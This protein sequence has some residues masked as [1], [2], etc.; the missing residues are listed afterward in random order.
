MKSKDTK[1]NE[2]VVLIPYVCKKPLS[3]AKGFHFEPGDEIQFIKTEVNPDRP[4][5]KLTYYM[6]DKEE[7]KM[8]S[9]VFAKTFKKMK[10]SKKKVVAEEN[11]EDD[12]FGGGGG[13]SFSF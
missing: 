3:I 8:D 5:Q 4:E 2:E 9:K 12:M 13:D 6:R 7:R 1:E 11:N 10:V